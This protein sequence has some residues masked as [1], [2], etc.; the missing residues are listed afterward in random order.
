[1]RGQQFEL[2]KGGQTYLKK[3]EE[4]PDDNLNDNKTTNR[5][6]TE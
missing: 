4:W 1:M 2:Q 3:Q 6:H 5:S